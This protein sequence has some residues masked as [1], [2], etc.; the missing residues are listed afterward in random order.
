MSVLNLCW[1][2]FTNSFYSGTEKQHVADDYAKRLHMGEVECRAVMSA[3]FNI[4]AV[5][6]GPSNVN[7]A[8]CEYLN[9]SIC[10][11]SETGEVRIVSCVM[12]YLTI[13]NFF[14]ISVSLSPSLSGIHSF[15]CSSTIYWV[16][17][18]LDRYEYHLSMS[19]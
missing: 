14:F 10:P 12:H 7:F 1:L 5:K 8:F 4:M 3:A 13:T 19:L 6:G 11:I 16:I 2:I 9:I 18:G 17:H 15:I